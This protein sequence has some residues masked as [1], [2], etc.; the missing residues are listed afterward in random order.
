MP[1]NHLYDTWKT[2]NSGTATWAA[3]H[4]NPQFCLADHWNLSK[5]VGVSEPDC[6]EDP[7][8]SQA[9]EC[10]PALEPVVG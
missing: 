5:P 2:P 7:W 4:P 6:R 9:D 8:R 1:I 10:H 3:D